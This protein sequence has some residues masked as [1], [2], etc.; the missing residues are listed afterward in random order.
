MNNL[1]RFHVARIA[2][3]KQILDLYQ[4]SLRANVDLNIV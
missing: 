3:Y 2:Q 4:L 1:R